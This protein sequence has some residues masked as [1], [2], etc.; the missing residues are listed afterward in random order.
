[1]P[2]FFLILINMF[3]S[4]SGLVLSVRGL[5]LTPNKD[6]PVTAQNAL[7]RKSGLSRSF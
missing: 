5:T 2:Q 4:F 7:H 1:M 3:P 6:C